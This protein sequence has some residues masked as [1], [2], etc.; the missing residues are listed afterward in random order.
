MIKLESHETLTQVTVSKL[1]ENNN[2]ILAAFIL[3][4]KPFARGVGKIK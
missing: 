3:K 2:K 4:K 1:Q